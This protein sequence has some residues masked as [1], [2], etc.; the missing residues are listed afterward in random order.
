MKGFFMSLINL[1]VKQAKPKEKPYKL[2]DAKDTYLFINPK[3]QK[4]WHM[5][6]R[7]GGKRKTLALKIIPIFHYTRTMFINGSKE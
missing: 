3:G 5:D 2:A 4:Y 1:Q 6:Y 7:Y